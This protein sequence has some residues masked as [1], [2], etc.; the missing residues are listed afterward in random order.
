MSR[1]GRIATIYEAK[2]SDA[3]VNKN[4]RYFSE[5]YDLNGIQ[6]VKSLKHEIQEGRLQVRKAAA[7]LKSLNP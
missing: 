4:L 3:S 1:D 7:F 5:Q 6:I 2:S